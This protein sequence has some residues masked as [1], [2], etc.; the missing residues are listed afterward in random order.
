MAEEEMIQP[1][2]DYVANPNIKDEVKSEH[3]DNLPGPAIS[4]PGSAGGEVR[5]DLEGG[6]FA[7]AGPSVTPHSGNL[8]EMR[9]G[10]DFMSSPMASSSGDIDK[11]AIPRGLAEAERHED[12]MGAAAS[13]P[14]L[15]T[16][17]KDAL[18][19]AGVTPAIPATHAATASPAIPA[20]PA[21][22]ALSHEA[23]NDLEGG[24]P[25]AYT[26]GAPVVNVE[27][28]K[29]GATLTTTATGA[30]I[31]Q[32]PGHTPYQ[33]SPPTASISSPSSEVR[34]DL[35][36]GG[37]STIPVSTAPHSPAPTL[38]AESKSALDG[39]GAAVPSSLSGHEHAALD[40]GDMGVTELDK[41]KGHMPSASHGINFGMSDTN[42]HR[43]GMQQPL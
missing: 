4:V 43:P 14:A 25:P 10:G 36:I 5:N 21:S 41:P 31:E 15:N 42:I 30:R 23:R 38:S 27:H 16:E 8:P 18:E 13:S 35:E 20:T 3:N 26:G 22:P 40:G 19:G 6:G 7:G 12:S 9:G 17:A 29:N 2:G 33:V 1:S 34:N 28:L 37:G 11:A 32:A 24:S 39:G